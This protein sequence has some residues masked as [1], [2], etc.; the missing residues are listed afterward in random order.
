MSHLTKLMS[1]KPS[2][3][4]FVIFFSNVCKQRKLKT[5]THFLH[6]ESISEH[7]QSADIYLYITHFVQLSVII[8][9]KY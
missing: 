3:L 5:N 2:G 6:I 7:A 9:I 4:G 8:S 1:K